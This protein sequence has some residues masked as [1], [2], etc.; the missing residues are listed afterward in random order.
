MAALSVRPVS[1]EVE[2]GS[3][4]VMSP[5]QDADSR[6][7]GGTEP[8]Q[9]SRRRGGS[10][11]PVARLPT[12]PGV[13][14]EELRDAM[15]SSDEE[16]PGAGEIRPAQRTE[17][18]SVI[19]LTTPDAEAGELPQEPPVAADGGGVHPGEG[20]FENG[21]GRV[22]MDI[23]G[24]DGQQCAAKFIKFKKVNGEPMVFGTLGV[25]H[26][27]YAQPLMA[28]PAMT[29]SHSPPQKRASMRNSATPTAWTGRHGEASRC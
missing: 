11:P 18:T 27:E 26:L 5:P 4:H 19:D 9:S 13:T 3:Y 16:G 28:A 20:W 29:S 10:L 7:T 1:P 8:Q 24:E 22:H 6:R 21:Y 23:R 17:A 2:G 25:G 14:V 12:P 15:R